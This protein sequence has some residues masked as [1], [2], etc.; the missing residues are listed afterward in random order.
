MSGDTCFCSD[1]QLQDRRFH[2]FLFSSS[3]STVRHEWQAEQ[4]ERLFLGDRYPDTAAPA[5]D[6]S[7]FKR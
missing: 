4:H 5:I 1:E 7:K 2:F 3:T 6:L